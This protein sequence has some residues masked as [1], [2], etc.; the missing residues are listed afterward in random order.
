MDS[1]IQDLSA[2]KPFSFFK[3]GEKSLKSDWK[4]RKLKK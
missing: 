3:I 4:E 2:L 1:S